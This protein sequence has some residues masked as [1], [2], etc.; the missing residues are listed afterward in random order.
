MANRARYWVKY[1]GNW[2]SANTQL[3][4][5]PIQFDERSDFNISPD[6]KL[7][8]FIFI[9]CEANAKPIFQMN[10]LRRRRCRRQHRCRQQRIPLFHIGETFQLS[11][12][13]HQP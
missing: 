12:D 5:K 4:L 10:R 8:S 13:A 3:D 7:H 1:Y 11:L 2:R 6:V 9:T